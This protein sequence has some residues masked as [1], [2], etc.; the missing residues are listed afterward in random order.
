MRRTL[1]FASRSVQN[2][3]TNFYLKYYTAVKRWQTNGIGAKLVT[4]DRHLLALAA[5]SS[6]HINTLP[7]LKIHSSP[8]YSSDSFMTDTFCIHNDYREQKHRYKTTQRPIPLKT[9]VVWDVTP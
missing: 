7:H 1:Q 4:A 9:A 2:T 8:M 5:T 6:A 3:S